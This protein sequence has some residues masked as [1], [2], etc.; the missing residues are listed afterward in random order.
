MDLGPHAGLVAACLH[1]IGRAADARRIVDSLETRLRAGEQLDTMFTNV[2]AAQDLASFYGWTGDVDRAVDWLTEAYGQ[3]PS[4]V[5]LRT[6]E[7]GMFDQVRDDP[8]FDAELTRLRAD[9]WPRVSAERRRVK[10]R[11]LIRQ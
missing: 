8:W 2:V 9:I 11:G 5:D 1:E 6:I 7:S 3:S 4:G 10:A